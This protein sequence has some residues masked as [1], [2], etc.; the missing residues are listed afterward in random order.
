MRVTDARLTQVCVKTLRQGTRELIDRLYAIEVSAHAHPWTWDNIHSC[1]EE[2]YSCL[3]TGVFAGKTLMG[4]AAVSIVYDEAE[5]W[6]IGVARAYQ[7]HGY[8]RL[9]LEGSLALATLCQ[10]KRCFLEVRESNRVAI[11]LYES[12][13]FKRAG[14]RKNYYEP[15]GDHPAENAMTMSLDLES[16]RYAH[17]NLEGEVSELARYLRA[18]P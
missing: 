5:L 7:G 3:N 8:G 18:L 15:Y 9:L 1:F 6:T 10:A 2:N 13:G 12:H 14:V 11:A 16:S 17:L 4:Y